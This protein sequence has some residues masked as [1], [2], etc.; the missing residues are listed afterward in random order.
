MLGPLWRPVKAGGAGHWAR[1]AGASHVEPDVWGCG[2]LGP[3]LS[4]LR[5]TPPSSAGNGPRL[6]DPSSGNWEGAGPERPS[7]DSNGK[8]GAAA[9]ATHRGPA[10]R[11]AHA[12]RARPAPL[13]PGTRHSR[14]FAGC[15][16]A[17]AAAILL[18]RPARGEPGPR[19][20]RSPATAW[21][22]IPLPIAAGGADSTPGPPRRR[23]RPGACRR[24]PASSGRP[25]ATCRPGP[26]EPAP[27][28]PSP[29]SREGP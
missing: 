26:A 6:S 12:P 2:P 19:E 29:L 3:T 28:G 17:L 15:S 9:L 27:P 7:R 24:R 1:G 20:G 11:R 10:H 14:H 5:E 21:P 16:L 23:P 18:W 22:G 4:R 13:H 8:P 25:Q